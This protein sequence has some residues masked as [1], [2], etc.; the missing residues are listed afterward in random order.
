MEFEVYQKTLEN[1]Y[2]ELLQQEY[3]K[4]TVFDAIRGGTLTASRAYEGAE[5]RTAGHKIMVIGRAMN[6]WGEFSEKST[7]EEILAK[8]LRPFGKQASH[9]DY[10]KPFC[11]IVNRDGNPY[12]ITENGNK[13]N[14]NYHYARSKFWKLIKQLLIA[15]DEEDPSDCF[16]YHEKNWH[17]KIVWSNLYKISPKDYGNPNS[18]QIKMQI[19]I[20][21]N[22]LK[23]EIQFYQPEFILFVTDHWYM[24]PFEDGKIYFHEFADTK[25]SDDDTINIVGQSNY[26]DAKVIVCKRPDRR[27]MSND[28]IRNMA[29]EIYATFE[30]ME[31]LP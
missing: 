24:C 26:G 1:L 20:C 22:I 13:K 5:Y 17:Q 14:K 27:G 3:K 12:P 18:Q 7:D 23:A 31:C 9:C 15:F 21:V 28:K 29:H 19:D 4:S 16:Y 11:D 8:I 6:G 30:R 10:P 25:K 2:Q